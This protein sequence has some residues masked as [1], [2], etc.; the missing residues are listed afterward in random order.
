MTKCCQVNAAKPESAHMVCSASVNI[1]FHLP[2][3]FIL[4]SINLIAFVDNL[5]KTYKLPNRAKTIKK[6]KSAAE[7]MLVIFIGHFLHAII[8]EIIRSAIEIAPNN[9]IMRYIT[10]SSGL[11]PVFQLV[12]RKNCDGTIYPSCCIIFICYYEG[13]DKILLLLRS[14]YMLLPCR[15]KSW[16]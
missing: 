16:C 10:K 11:Q 4:V 3:F 15:R 14:W 12:Y 8:A 5:T 9:S 2:L 13:D 1:I 6:Q 7:T